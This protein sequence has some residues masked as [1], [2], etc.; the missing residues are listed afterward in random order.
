MGVLNVIP[1]WGKLLGIAVLVLIYRR[2]KGDPGGGGRVVGIVGRMGSGKSF[3]AVRMAYSR[4]MRGTTVYSNFTMNLEP[5]NGH[6]PC[7]ERCAKQKRC[8]CVRHCPCQLAGRWHRF[9]GWEQFAT[10]TNA[11]VIIDE[12][13]LY[14]P[15]HDPR[16]IPDYVRWKLKMCRKHKIDLYWIAQH[17]S[18]VARLL[19]D[20]LTN[21][22]RVCQSWLGGK[23]FSAKT[24]DPSTVRRQRKH[25][26]RSG[27]FMRPHIAGLYDTLETIKGDTE[28]GDGTMAAANAMSDVLQS[29]DLRESQERSARLAAVLA[30]AK[31]K[32]KGPM[33]RKGVN[34]EVREHDREHGDSE[35]H[36]QSGE[37]RHEAPSAAEAGV[38]SGV[39]APRAVLPIP[40]GGPASSAKRGRPSRAPEGARER[41]EHEQRSKRAWGTCKACPAELPARV[42]L[43]PELADDEL[44]ADA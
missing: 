19:R 4:M 34:N 31:P 43:R 42:E 39:P 3:F 16:C 12:V 29:E 11:V 30:E 1:T 26:G 14:A 20:V 44:P 2:T 15:S 5:K 33:P 7:P 10:I 35:S 24:Y 41:C 18:R 17:E 8:K 22:I 36:Q 25:T 13:D 28:R 21:E 40:G 38:G 27:Y 9:E 37:Q 23:Y 32:G 6:P